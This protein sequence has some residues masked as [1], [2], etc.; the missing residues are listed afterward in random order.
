MHVSTLKEAQLNMCEK[1]EECWYRCKAHMQQDGYNTVKIMSRDYQP[2]DLIWLCTPVQKQGTTRKLRKPWRGPY[3][4]IRKRSS[5]LY[6]V[7]L[8]E[9]DQ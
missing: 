3:R 6:D 8:V 5:V 7:R 4:V 2:R 1:V 9:G